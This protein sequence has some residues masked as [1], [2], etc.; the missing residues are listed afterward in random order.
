ME[1]NLSN[2][3]NFNPYYYHYNGDAD[4]FSNEPDTSKWE[5]LIRDRTENMQ[6]ATKMNILLFLLWYGNLQNFKIFFKNLDMI[7]N[8]TIACS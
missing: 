4:F 2:P 3:P 5:N 1:L 8:N 7:P 6:A